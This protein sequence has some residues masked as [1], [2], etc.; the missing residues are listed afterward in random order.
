MNK[1]FLNNKAVEKSVHKMLAFIGIVF[2]AGV[3]IQG[4]L[5]DMS[6]TIVIEVEPTEVKAAEEVKPTST[7]TPSNDASQ[8]IKVKVSHYWPELGGVN[9]LTFVNG[10]CISRMANGKTWQS[11]VG[12][13]V[14]ACPPELEFGTQ[15]Y[16]IDFDR[17][18]TCTD[19]GSAIVK[20]VNGEYWIDLL[21]PKALVPYGKVME[22][23]I[24][25]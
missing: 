11:G 10:E 16:L 20:T 1:L 13:D 23:E 12:Q 24:L 15:L 5:K 4:Q 18:F 22:A 9:C 14:M 7:P 19:R 25:K 21:L 2:Y 6:N 8:F 3:I 17:T